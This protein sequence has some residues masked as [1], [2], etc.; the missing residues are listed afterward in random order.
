MIAIFG[1][2]SNKFY[3]TG[4]EMIKLKNKEEVGCDFIRGG[5]LLSFNFKPNYLNKIMS[6]NIENYFYIPKN[7][8]IGE[9]DLWVIDNLEIHKK[10]M[11]TFDIILL[12]N[13]KE[14]KISN[15]PDFYLWAQTVTN[16]EDKQ[17]IEKKLN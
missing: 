3:L 15:E 10:C 6:S 2:E 13:K 12:Y 16:I 4:K 17:N 9:S 14:M 1:N 11:G 8:I 7:K 5:R